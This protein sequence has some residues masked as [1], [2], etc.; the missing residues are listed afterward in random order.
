MYFH[1]YCKRRST[2]VLQ[3]LEE[4]KAILLCENGPPAVLP[5]ITATHIIFQVFGGII[6]VSIPSIFARSGVY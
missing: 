4:E 5:K 6:Q 3:R 1:F 2:K